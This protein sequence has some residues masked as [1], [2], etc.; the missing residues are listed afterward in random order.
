MRRPFSLVGNA[1]ASLRT[2]RTGSLGAKVQSALGREGFNG[3]RIVSAGNIPRGGFSSSSAVT[4][5]TKNALNALFDLGIPPDMLVHLSCQAEYGT[6]VRAGSLDQ[7]TEQKGRAGQGA[8]ISSNP[9][10]NY[11]ILGTYPVPAQRFQVLFPYSVDRDRAAW[12]WSAGVYAAEPDCGRPTTGEMRKM[13]GKAA[14]LAA[15]LLRLPLDRIFSSRWRATFLPRGPWDW[16]T[17]GGFVKF[18]ARFL[19][20]YPNKNCAARSKNSGAGTSS[21]WR[22]SKNLP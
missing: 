20:S 8:L 11:K 7:A 12:R 3:L 22:N 10:D 21:S 1:I 14:E 13:T 4:V 17:G 6:G 5:A 9:R 18:C 19:S 2:V 15:I 16:P